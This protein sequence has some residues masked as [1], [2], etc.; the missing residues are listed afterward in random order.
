MATYVKVSRQMVKPRDIAGDTEEEQEA[1][2]LT[3]GSRFNVSERNRMS[4][5]T[6]VLHCAIHGPFIIARF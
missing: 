2:F 3:N 6:S 5:H 1:V 4:V